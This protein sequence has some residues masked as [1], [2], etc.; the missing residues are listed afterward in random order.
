MSMMTYIW[1]LKH[2]DFSHI[3]PYFWLSIFN[4][5]IIIPLFL[6]KLVF[7]TIL[8]NGIASTIESLDNYAGKLR[9]SK[10]TKQLEWARDPNK[11]Y[12]IFDLCYKDFNRFVDILEYADEDLYLELTQKREAILQA[13]WDR[14]AKQKEAAQQS[15]IKRKAMITTIVKYTKPVLIIL[16]WGV[17]AAIIAIVALFL[18]KIIRFFI[19]FDYPPVNWATVQLIVYF[20]AAIAIAVFIVVRTI[21][22]LV[23]SRICR[24]AKMPAWLAAVGRGLRWVGSGIALFWSVVVQMVQSNCPGIDWED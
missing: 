10:L 13:K 8:Y 19:L 5:I 2:Y 22:W 21:V 14:E 9:K 17:I 7:K 15:S 24:T 12:R 11:Q 4:L 20:M 16:F 1:G 6:I 18:Y 23:N 3:C